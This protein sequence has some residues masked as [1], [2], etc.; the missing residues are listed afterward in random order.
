MIAFASDDDFVLE[1]KSGMG[2]RARRTLRREQS[3]TLD[4]MFHK[5]HTPLMHKSWEK[6]MSDA[7]YEMR[8]SHYVYIETIHQVLAPLPQDIISIIQAKANIPVESM[9][10]PKVLYVAK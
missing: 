9:P 10:L 7:K 1:K 4:D 2:R 6:M 8:R 3:L 5:V